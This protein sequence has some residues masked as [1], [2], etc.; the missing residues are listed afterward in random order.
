MPKPN[1]GW[2]PARWTLT[3]AFSIIA[4]ARYR[5]TGRPPSPL[6]TASLLSGT[7]AEDQISILLVDDDPGILETLVDIFEE[8][9][10]QTET[11]STGRQALA[12]IRQRFF[13]L[14]LLDIRLPDMQGTELLARARELQGDMQCIM[15]TGNASL[16][17]A[18]DSL[19]EGA[20][21]YLEKPIELPHVKATVRRALEQQQLQLSNRRLLNQLQALGEITTAALATLEPRELL[22]RL[23]SNLIQQHGADG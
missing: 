15:A 9:G 20:Y 8:M 23:L 5:L 10:F 6:T 1:R 17:T 4:N 13:N 22:V 19:N 18:L 2:R 12:K 16:P 3:G 7:S 14:A 21:A 11:A